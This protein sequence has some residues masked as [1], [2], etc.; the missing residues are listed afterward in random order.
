MEGLKKTLGNAP[1]YV[2]LY[3]VAMIPTYILPYFGS[4]SLIATAA[5]NNAGHVNGPFWVHLSFLLILCGLAWTRGAV[6]DKKWLVIFPV[7]AAFFD[8]MPG[9]NIIPLVPT[10][11]HVL[12]IILGVSSSAQKT[13]S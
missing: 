3:L 5:Y 2:T 11:M 1:T 13:A 9:F 4:N 8:L 10:V 6:V 12:A 7:L